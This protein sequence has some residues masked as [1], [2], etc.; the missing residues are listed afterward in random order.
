MSNALD[1]SGQPSGCVG[2]AARR[3][4][5]R[6][7]NAAT[8]GDADYAQGGVDTAARAGARAPTYRFGEPNREPRK[9]IL[10]RRKRPRRL[11][12]HQSAYSRATPQFGKR[13]VTRPRGARGIR[14]NVERQRRDSAQHNRKL[15]EFDQP[16]RACPTPAIDDL[17]IAAR[18]GQAVDRRRVD[19]AVEPYGGPARAGPPGRCVEPLRDGE[20]VG[21]RFGQLW[22]QLPRDRRL[23]TGRG[24]GLSLGLQ[25]GADR[26]L[27]GLEAGVTPWT[28]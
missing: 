19:H 24:G 7:A 14:Q 25:H 28:H 20:V 13:G 5:C 11:S 18:L 4:A 23:T 26:Q 1:G 6:N 17:L 2:E 8:D 27:A 22:R 15:D 12:D 16:E 3:D 10:P 21:L 9:R